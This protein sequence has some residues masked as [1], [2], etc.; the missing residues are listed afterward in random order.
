LLSISA[1]PRDILQ[2]RTDGLQAEQFAVDS[3]ATQILS[4][5]FS[6]NALKLDSTYQTRTATSSDRTALTVKIPAGKTPQTGKFQVTPARKA[7]AQQLV[8]NRFDAVDGDL[9]EGTLS[10]RVG[11]FINKG[12][13]LDSLNHGA[14]VTRGSIK[15]TDRAGESAVIDLSLALTVDDV[16][17]T[18]NETSS[19]SVTA[20]VQGD[21]FVLEDASG[22]SG[23]LSVQEVG[24][25]STAAD[26][27]LAGLSVTQD[28]GTGLDVFSL[29][30]GTR[31]S[32]LNNGAGVFFSKAGVDD[33][34]ITLADG[35]NAGIDLSAAR[36]LGDVIDAIEG[37]EALSGKITA[38][39]AADGNRLELVDLTTGSTTFEVAA[40][41]GGTAAADLGLVGAGVAG[42]LTGT[43]LVAGL[44]DTLLSQLNGGAGVGALGT[45]NIV[46]RAGGDAQVDLSG[47]ETLGDVVQLI[48]DA[49]GVQV[50]ASINKA[51]N[52][53]VITD[54]S[55]GGD[56]LV[57]ENA[58]ASETAEALR[59]AVAAQVGSVDSGSLKLQTTSL[60]TRLATLSGQT[61]FRLGDLRI[62]DA[63][64]TTKIADLNAAGAE[65][66]TVGD[67]ID[68]INDLGLDVEA[69]LND[70]GDGILLVSTAD[71]EATGELTV[72]DVS[73]NVAETLNLTRAATTIQIE[74]VDTQVIDG[75]S[76]Y[77]VD[78]AE[79]GQGAAAED[80]LLSSLKGGAGIDRGDVVITDSTGTA[81]FALDLN[82]SDSGVSTV[83]QLIDLINSRA[84]ASGVGVTARVNTSG[85]G[86]ELEDTAGGAGLLTV[87]DVNGTSAADL[88]LAGEAKE[89]NGKQT[90]NG[91]NLFAATSAA[92]HGIEAL[93]ARINELDAG[94]TASTIFD[95]IGYRLSLNVDET[96][97]ANELLLDGALAGLSFTEVTKAQDA[98]LA[99]GGLTAAD[100]VLVSSPTDE[101]NE[102]L[103]G[104]DI[105]VAQASSSPVTI[106]VA[107]D[108]KPLVN[109]VQDLVDSYNAIRESL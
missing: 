104:V 58:D 23:S 25:G 55:G 87:R 93:A 22:G 26:L 1:R 77:A 5:Q 29:H 107:S 65:A 70:A 108:D 96:G 14:G 94:V 6:T 52:G 41:A 38:R 97:S 12:V 44:N 20:S 91:A 47:A 53:I 48:N 17:E 99:Y 63:N 27:G 9:G 35:T 68:A 106:T 105:T 15:I 90:I 76:T 59:I 39:I 73:G 46:D 102:V 60:A 19:I 56:D 88:K 10:F 74:D 7:S 81:S 28:V 13:S 3:L 57:V 69:R 50:A 54:A 83:G 43:R 82:G 72:Q 2:S 31:L 98:L 103:G 32:S 85:T 42:T 80:T 33:L 66:E 67:V 78:L 34:D 16:L 100:G 89:A 101:F 21:R 109:K 37:D 45:L 8:S 36:T 49:S 84:A 71:P 11:G 40:G 24:G 4:L 30:E 51:R 62:T 64:G 86:I 95:G 92:S 75:T 18:I 79:I 61:T